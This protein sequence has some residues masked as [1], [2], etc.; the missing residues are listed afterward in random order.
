MCR[1]RMTCDAWSTTRA[2]RTGTVDVLVTNAGVVAVT[3]PTDDWEK[4]LANY[5]H[6]LGTNL[7]GVFL[8]GRAVAPLMVERG[9]GEIVTSPPTTCILADGPTPS[10][11]L[12][13]RPARGEVN[14]A[15]PGGST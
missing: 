6:V 5:D 1:S 3:S 14:G 13:R 12:T 10:I 4:S 9:H 8:F 2:A 11:T 15:Q 7:K